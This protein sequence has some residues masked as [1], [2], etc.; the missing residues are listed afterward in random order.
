MAEPFQFDIVYHDKQLIY[1]AELR[2]YGYTY[3]IAVQVNGTEI[4]FE[5]DEE[6]NFRAVVAEPSGKPVP[7]SGLL[8]AITNRL[9]EL[10]R[11]Q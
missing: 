5:P 1:N 9:H 3:K 10:F 2:V 4:L 6:R 7:D 11:D 8:E